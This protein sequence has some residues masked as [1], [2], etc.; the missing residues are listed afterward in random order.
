MSVISLGKLFLNQR[1]VA[2]LAHYFRLIVAFCGGISFDTISLSQ[3][4]LACNFLGACSASFMSYL[5]D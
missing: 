4:N 1:L 2:L 3:A 5:L